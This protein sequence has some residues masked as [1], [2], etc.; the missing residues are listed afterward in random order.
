MVH[1]RERAKRLNRPSPIHAVRDTHRCYDDAVDL[2]LRRRARRGNGKNDPRTEVV[3]ATHNEA[4]VARAVRVMDEPD[5]APNNDG[6]HFAQ[7]YGMSDN[8][9]FTLGRGGYNAFKYLSYGKVD[10]VV[11]YLVRRAQ[12]NGDV[13][14][15]AAKEMGLL[16]EELGKRFFAR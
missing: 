9:T 1:E 8:L 14:G 13:L 5:L 10:E 3:I 6:V 2:L 15:N 11:P 4:S 7:L 16:R 12:E